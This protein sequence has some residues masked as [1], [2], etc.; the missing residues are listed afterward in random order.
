M[1]IK[2]PE[3]QTQSQT[4][5]PQQ[6]V[7][8]AQ[9]PKRKGKL[10][11]VLIIVGIAIAAVLAYG[12]ANAWLLNQNVDEIA[13][14]F[15]I[16]QDKWSASDLD[17]DKSENATEFLKKMN[18]IKDDSEAAIKEVES[19]RVGSRASAYKSDVENYYTKAT[20]YA[21]K[22]VALGNYLK[23]MMD[24][25]TVFTDI[26]EN[27]PDTND[28]EVLAKYY[29]KV[30]K[31]LN[32]QTS[33]MKNANPPSSLEKFNNQFVVGLKAFSK[34]IDQMIEALERN[35][36][37]AVNNAASEVVKASNRFN[38]IEF[39]GEDEID[40]DYVTQKQIKEMQALENKV[41][42][43]REDLSGYIFILP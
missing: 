2:K 39:P 5:P 42:A 6:P 11:W 41:K 7:Q 15:E 31:D 17:K 14:T 27:T 1:D 16:S 23:L 9:Q 20:E 13:S 38:A 32:D 4:P 24:T 18:T 34:S 43:D 12:F 37:E 8:T 40:E 36:E 10:K 22:G 19:V 35:D 33:K 3:E 29:K 28:P 30:K 21:E 25:E 26:A